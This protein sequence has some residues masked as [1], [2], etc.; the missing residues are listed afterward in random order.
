[1]RTLGRLPRSVP[2]YERTPME[3]RHLYRIHPSWKLVPCEQ[4]SWRPPP[5][6]G[7]RRIGPT[8]SGAPMGPNWLSPYPKPL[9][10]WTPLSTLPVDQQELFSYPTS[11]SATPA[12]PQGAHRSKEKNL[13]QLWWDNEQLEGQTLTHHPLY[14]PWY[15]DIYLSIKS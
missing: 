2:K 3:D 6:P 9:T 8:P 12:K 5:L 14:P 10:T 11:I 4:S 7:Q 1:M 13:S 15:N